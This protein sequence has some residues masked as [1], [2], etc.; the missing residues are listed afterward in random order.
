MTMMNFAAQMK[1]GVFSHLTRYVQNLATHTLVNGAPSYMPSTCGANCSFSLVLD[2]PYF[3]CTS[4]TSN[5]SFS[6]NG[7]IF[8]FPVFNATWEGYIF[9]ATK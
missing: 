7:S 4:T 5:V 2:V 1:M 6:C 3:E 8:D 9:K